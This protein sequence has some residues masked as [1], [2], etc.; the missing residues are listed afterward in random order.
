[1]RIINQETFLKVVKEKLPHYD[2]SKSIYTNSLNP[3]LVI[4]PIHGVFHKLSTWLARGAGCKQCANISAGNKLRFNLDIFIEKAQKRHGVL[5]DYSK[6]VYTGSKNKIEVVCRKHGSFYITPSAHL[7]GTKCNKCYNR[8]CFTKTKWRDVCNQRNSF[9]YLMMLTTPKEQCIKIG[10]TTNIKERIKG[11]KKQKI[12]VDLLNIIEFSNSDDCYN[13][14]KMFFRNLKKFKYKPQH[15]F[16][17]MT[18]CFIDN[19]LVIQEFQNLKNKS[20]RKV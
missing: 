11:L 14:E 10:M 6:V 7:G 12:L 2:Y 1:M 19:P 18:E 8:S 9:V 17:G 3:V 5:Y 4:C 15:K 16:G 20:L 13:T